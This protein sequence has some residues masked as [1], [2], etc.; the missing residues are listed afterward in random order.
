MLKR[1]LFFYP[2]FTISILLLLL[3][4]AQ[5]PQRNVTRGIY[6]WRTVFTL[7]KEEISWL[8]E[9]EIKKLYV[10]FFDVDWNPQL[11]V[12][13]PVGD[14]TVSTKSLKGIEIIPVIFITN[15]TLKN[16]HDS[17]IQELADNIYR[18]VISKASVFNSIED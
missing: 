9:N 1:S 14:V 3:S 13:L 2:I 17:L 11:S 15:R 12:A 5:N 10:K 16:M 8:N 7:S 4:C 18:K 6:F